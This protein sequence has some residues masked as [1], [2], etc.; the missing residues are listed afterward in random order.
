MKNKKYFVYILTNYSNTTLYIGVTS[1]LRG[2]VYQH[3]HKLVDG[4]TKK[5][6]LWKLVYYGVFEDVESAIRREKQIKS[7]SRKKKEDLIEGKNSDWEKLKPW[8]DEES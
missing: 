8:E 3:K 7:W 1:G 5:Y 4:F 2:R 6:N